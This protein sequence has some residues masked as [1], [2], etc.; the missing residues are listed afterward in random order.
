MKLLQMELL[1]KDT[2]NKGL[3]YGV[4]NV[5]FLLVATFLISEEEPMDTSL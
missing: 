3:N 4:P 2:P 1:I 5:N